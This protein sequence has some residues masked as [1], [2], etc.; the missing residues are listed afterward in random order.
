[1]E[2]APSTAVISLRHS[3]PQSFMSTLMIQKPSTECANLQSNTDSDSTRIFS[4]T[5]LVIVVMDTTNLTSLNSLSLTCMR[6]FAKSK[7]LAL[8]YTMPSS[9]LKASLKTVLTRESETRLLPSV[10]KNSLRFQ[11][12]RRQSNSTNQ[13]VTMEPLL[14]VEIGKI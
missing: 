8:K 13:K 1:M 7:K 6:R 2:E 11:L 14:S 10:I 5:L 12:S 3:I 4:L 9:S